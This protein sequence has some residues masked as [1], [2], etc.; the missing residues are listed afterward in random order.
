MIALTAAQVRYELTLNLLAFIIVY[1]I[2][3]FIFYTWRKMKS[4]EL[5]IL[6]IAFTALLLKNLLTIFVDYRYI[7]MDILPFE[8][9][10]SIATMALET[11]GYILIASSLLLHFFRRYKRYVAYFFYGIVFLL[12][13]FLILV[14][15]DYANEDAQHFEKYGVHLS[16]REHTIHNFSEIYNIVFLFFG[17]F[18]VFNNWK[19]EK[20]TT[21]V[22][23]MMGML[24]WIIAHIILVVYATAVAIPEVLKTLAIMLLAYAFAVK[25]ELP[26]KVIPAHEVVERKVEGAK[27]HLKPSSTYYFKEDKPDKTFDCFVDQVMHGKEGLSITRTYPDQIRKNYGLSRTPIIWLTQTP[28]EKFKYIKPTSLVQLANIIEEFINESDDNLIMIDG[29]D[30]LIT[31]NTFQEVLKFFQNLV[32]KV[33]LLNSILVL[34]LNHNTMEN[35][36]FNLLISSMEELH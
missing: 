19:S 26:I 14:Q 7:F 33:A 22:V 21:L 4:K 5:L 20:S 6:S 17:F 34:S 9:T 15:I 28:T 8:P 16:P 29:V 12:F 32:E 25:K 31:Q 3:V 30:Y 2:V 1:F 18:V 23:M 35:K 24:S 36:E 27:Y 10:Y 13:L 11:L